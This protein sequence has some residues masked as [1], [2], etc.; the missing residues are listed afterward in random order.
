MTSFLTIDRNTDDFRN[1]ETIENGLLKP[2]KHASAP[3]RSYI[4]R[5]RCRSSESPFV[6]RSEMASADRRRTRRPP[7]ARS[8]REA[9]FIPRYRNIAPRKHRENGNLVYL[10]QIWCTC[11][12]IKYQVYFSSA[13]MLSFI[14]SL[15][16]AFSSKT[17]SPILIGR[18]SYVIFDCNQ[19]L[20]SPKHKTAII[21]PGNLIRDRTLHHSPPPPPPPASR[22]SPS[23]S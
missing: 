7:A 9:A 15:I 18:S 22:P 6:M 11:C 19:T 13:N 14:N 2:I 12:S 20:S 21:P 3:I 8:P 23:A 5:H 10:C 17:D 4:P 16:S 1:L